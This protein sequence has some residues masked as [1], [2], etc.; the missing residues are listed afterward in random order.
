MTRSPVVPSVAPA[1]GAVVPTWKPDGKGTRKSV[2]N[3]K[4]AVDVITIAKPS[5]TANDGT[6]AEEPIAEEEDDDDVSEVRSERSASRGNP[7]EPEV[8]RVVTDYNEPRATFP[9]LWIDLEGGITESVWKL[10]IIWIKG[11]LMLHSGSTLVRSLFLLSRL[12]HEF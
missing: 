11:V 7:T 1:N 8:E 6:I 10:A 5:K 9:A 12:P 3:S 2:N 4:I